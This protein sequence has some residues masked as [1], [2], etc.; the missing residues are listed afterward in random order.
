MSVLAVFLPLI[1]AAIA[2]LL[3]FAPVAD[4]EAKHRYDLAAQLVTCGCMV[5]ASG[6]RTS[7]RSNCSHGLI[8]ARSKCHG[9]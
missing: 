5:T 4:K 9:L 1:G 7:A 3:I 8:P 2:G 6:K